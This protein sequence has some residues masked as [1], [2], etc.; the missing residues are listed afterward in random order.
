MAAPG[1][2]QVHTLANGKTILGFNLIPVP[3]PPLRLSDSL[4]GTIVVHVLHVLRRFG[5]GVA[6]QK[7]NDPLTRQNLTAAQLT[8]LAWTDKCISMLGKRCRTSQMT[9]GSDARPIST[10]GQRK[11]YKGYT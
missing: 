8:V 2:Q 3:H 6:V 4:S 5:A 10:K 7:L 1:G 9:P 11:R